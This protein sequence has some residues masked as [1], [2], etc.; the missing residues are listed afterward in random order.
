MSRT[1]IALLI[2]A[3][4][5]PAFIIAPAQDAQAEPSGAHWEKIGETVV[6]GKSDRDTMNVPSGKGA[7]TAIRIKVENGAIKLSDFKITFL[8][9]TTYEPTTQL[10][11]GGDTWSREFDLPGEVRIIKKIDF[12][13]SDLNAKDG[14]A[15]RVE[16]W[17]RDVSGP[18]TVKLGEHSVNGK[19][20]KDVFPVGESQGTFSA[21][22]FKAEAD[23]VRIYNVK[24]ILGNDQV[25]NVTAD[26][27]L[28][29]N[30]VRFVDLP[31]E[32]RLVKRVEFYYGN[33]GRDANARLELW[34]RR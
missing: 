2:A 3:L 25:L 1:R 29:R 21:V 20:D 26:F 22:A 10:F 28:K 27:T 9:G 30:E 23:N 34:G 17:G 19:V 13:F 4:A 14:K 7:Y 33:I 11:F 15:P 24:V 5:V 18:S 16:I 32:K 12:K 31:G 8:N 6:N